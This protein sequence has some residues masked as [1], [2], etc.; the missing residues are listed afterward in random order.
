MEP[1]SSQSSKKPDHCVDINKI[2][3]RGHQARH[4]REHLHGQLPAII[5]KYQDSLCY[6]ADLVF[7]LHHTNDA[8]LS[9]LLMAMRRW[10][11]YL[12]SSWSCCTCWR[13]HSS[14]RT[15]LQAL[16]KKS[17]FSCQS[18]LLCRSSS[19]WDA[20]ACPVSCDRVFV[21]RCWRRLRT[22]QCSSNAVPRSLARAPS[23][24]S[25]ARGKKTARP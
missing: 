18:P 10:I 14:R 22:C 15:H 8:A 1:F 11:P 17:S 23:K 20:G 13:D 5:P 9:T 16:P 12:M 6:T 19:P 4:G 24:A 2:S 7:G 3:C 21:T 25:A